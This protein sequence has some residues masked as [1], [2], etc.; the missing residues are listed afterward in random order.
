MMKGLVMPPCRMLGPGVQV[1]LP[2]LQVRLALL[3]PPRIRNWT[4][5]CR[6]LLLEPRVPNAARL[7]PRGRPLELSSCRC[8]R[9]RT[10]EVPGNGGNGERMRQLQLVQWP[11][12]CEHPG[13]ASA[14]PSHTRAACRFQEDVAPVRCYQGA[15]CDFF[16]FCRAGSCSAE[17][18]RLA[19]R[20]SEPLQVTQGKP[21]RLQGNPGHA[22]QAFA[23]ARQA[24]AAEPRRQRK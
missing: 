2:F 18:R 5:A 17:P 14:S 24:F 21:L 13:L 11:C 16:L 10:R 6:R 9:L 4:T 23:A 3:H 19:W 1:S 15:L 22:R 8:H 7:A 12:H 20:R